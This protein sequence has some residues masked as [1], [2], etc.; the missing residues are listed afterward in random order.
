MA[1]R[2]AIRP[3]TSDPNEL[4]VAASQI[5]AIIDGE[6]A[7]REV[8]LVVRRLIRDDEAR[9]RWERYHLIS[10]A[11]QGHLPDA[12]DARFA[13]HIRQMIDVE[14]PASAVK[15]PP[16]WYKPAARF[17]LAASV[18]AVA[19]F[20]FRL[21]QTDKPLSVSA[22][23]QF[24]VAPMSS[25]IPAPTA[26]LAAATDQEATQPGDP[27]QVR[28]NNYL[29]SHNSYASLNGMKGVL[30]YVRMVGYQTER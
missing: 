3:L 14:P 6:L 4:P 10:D 7:G 26:T 28:L 16:L 13:A 9:A 30:P 25:V 2:T 19:L 17:G 23:P 18:M 5:S 27:A 24:A 20:G 15:P 12:F 11:L 29:V 1:E 22:A 21:A 8:D